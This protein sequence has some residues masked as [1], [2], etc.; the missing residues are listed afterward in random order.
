MLSIDEVQTIGV[1][2]A[3]TMGAGI[4]Q[5]AAMAGYRTIMYDVQPATLEKAQAQIRQQLNT[6]VEKG[7]LTQAAADK[8]FHRLYFTGN[9]MDCSAE[10][11]IEAIVE[12][13]AS[14]I[15][16]FNQLSEMNHSD[17]VFAS[18]TSSL[19]IATIA[20]GVY[21]PARVA[22]MHF[23]N[24]PLRMQLVEI[25]HSPQTAPY[26]GDV[27]YQ[28]AKNFGKIPVH[29]K[30]TPGF[31]VNRVARQFYI[32]SMEIAS[33]TGADFKTIDR[34]LESAGFRMGPFALM[35]LIGQDINL[36]VSQSL[37]DAFEQAPRFKPHPLQISRVAQG[38]L[39]RKTGEGFYKY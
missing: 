39:G 15:A 25:V 16:L 38:K 29:A 11:F 12:N 26:V 35:D 36:A 17:V 13:P 7:K 6:A 10:I 19:S 28:L 21:N 22:G 31:I 14:K 23:F 1:C 37:H 5:M 32:E 30:D 9:L 27:L 18:N 4:A 20:K 33:S 24:P 3:G 2:G 8:A 34:L